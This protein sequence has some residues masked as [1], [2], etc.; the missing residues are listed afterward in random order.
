MEIVKPSAE[1]LSITPN[2][3][4]LIETAG[5]VCYQS[6]AD[7]QLGPE[8]FVRK[9]MQLGHESVIEHASASFRIVCDRGVTHE[10]VRHRLCSYSQESTR[11]VNYKKGIKVIKPPDLSVFQNDVWVRACE[12]AEKAY[13]LLIEAG[14]KP[15]I[16]RSVLPTCLKTEI[17]MSCD[18]REWRHFLHLRTAPAAHPQMREIAKMIEMAL[19]KECPVCFEDIAR[20]YPDDGTPPLCRFCRQPIKK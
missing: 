9:I 6:E 13:R 17:V 10:I 19:V 18:L 1:L 12:D 7:D 2:A 14:C 11:Y 20:C 4:G 8:P 3:L 5:R 15:Q 16:A